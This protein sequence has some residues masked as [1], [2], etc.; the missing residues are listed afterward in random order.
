VVPRHFVTAEMKENPKKV[1]S[2]ALT[3][4]GFLAV[5]AS[6]LLRILIEF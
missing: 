1:A 4:V 6:S 3:S 2:A 5:E